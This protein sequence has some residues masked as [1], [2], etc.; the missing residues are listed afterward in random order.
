MRTTIQLVAKNTKSNVSVLLIESSKKT[1][2]DLS[3]KVPAGFV[4]SE[5]KIDF[6]KDET[7]NWTFFVKK[8]QR[9]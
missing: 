8:R 2:S 5:K 1:A 7:G 6:V 4:S 3:K 9:C